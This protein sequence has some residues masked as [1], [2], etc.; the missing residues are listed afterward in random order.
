MDDRYYDEIANGYDQLYSDE[1]LKKL[2]FANDNFEILGNIIDIGCG[3]GISTNYYA[4]KTGIDPSNEL[5]S[6]AKKKYSGIK[7]IH[8]FAEEIPVE[9]ES[10]DFA[11]SFTAAQNFSN[12]KKAVLE[13]YRIV[14]KG[15]LITILKNS[16]KKEILK[17]E[18]SNL[19][20]NC[21][22]KILE[23]NKDVYFFVLKRENKNEN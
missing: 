4:C 23:D 10:Y 12:I 21:F 16:Q 8:G 15:F 3:T 2:K 20:E 22:I 7:F 13:F 1:Q 5:L 11:I 18:I 6:V 9:S 17:R 14:R 19:D